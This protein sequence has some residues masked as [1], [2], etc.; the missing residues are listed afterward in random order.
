MSDTPRTDAILRAMDAG[1]LPLN[2]PLLCMLEHARQLERELASTE[3]ERGISA[4][5]V[6]LCQPAIDVLNEEIKELRNALTSHLA[7][8]GNGEGK[9]F[10]TMITNGLKTELTEAQYTDMMK[11]S[12]RVDMS[13]ETM[14]PLEGFDHIYKHYSTTFGRYPDEFM[15]K[16]MAETEQ[17]LVLWWSTHRDEIRAALADRIAKP[18]AWRVRYKTTNVV[19]WKDHVTLSKPIALD[20]DFKQTTPLYARSDK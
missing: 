8:S 1:L 14:T 20:D 15:R 4:L 12:V 19:D 6:E 18:I 11:N 10:A 7:N 2:H 16:V 5:A 9:P 17:R 13:L 3:K